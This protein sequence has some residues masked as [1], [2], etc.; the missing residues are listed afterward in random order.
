[1][2]LDYT[3]I[4]APITGRIGRSLLDAGNLT[5][6]DGALAT[7][8]VTE[9]LY[10]YFD[11]SERSLLRLR[12]Q[13]GDSGAKDAKPAVQV[14]SATDEG[15][16]RRA[17][18]DFVD[19]RVDATTGTLRACA[20]LPNPKGELVPGMFVSVRISLGSPRKALLI[21]GSAIAR[22]DGNAFVLVV[23][24]KNILESRPVKAGQSVGQ[25]KVIDD[26][27]GRDEWVVVAGSRELRKPATR[28][29]PGRRRRPLRAAEG[30]ASARRGRLA[31][32]TADVPT[33]GPSVVRHGRLSGRQ[34]PHR[35]RG[36]GGADRAAARWV[37]GHVAPVLRLH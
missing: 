30:K 5:T 37:R 28:S 4:A 25:M 12:R 9:P 35:R 7:I 10:V 31:G 14:R 18:L 8:V 26:G 16:S 13:F 34:R 36:G 22:K 32:S 11:V 2:E 3:R 27:V 6:R 17:V 33:S 19:I 20:V 24:D 23:N 21:P 1:M 29:R 15:F